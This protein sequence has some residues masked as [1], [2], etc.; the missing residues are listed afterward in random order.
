MDLVDGDAGSDAYDGIDGVAAFGDDD[1]DVDGEVGAMSHT[2]VCTRTMSMS[3]TVAMLFAM[4]VLM[5]RTVAIR[6]TM[7]MMRTVATTMSSMTTVL[8]AYATWL[9]LS[10]ACICDCC[11]SCVIMTIDMAMCMVMSIGIYMH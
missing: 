9:L 10:P 5:T 7:P 1:D 11:M 6:M 4:A 2:I 8:I 3:M